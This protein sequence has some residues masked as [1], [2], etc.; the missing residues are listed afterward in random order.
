MSTLAI[1]LAATRR[2]A[3][4]SVKVEKSKHR[5]LSYRG[6]TADRD[7]LHTDCVRH[8]GKLVSI[9]RFMDMVD[10][11]Y[12][13]LEKA[14]VGQ[15][16]F[17]CINDVMKNGGRIR[18]FSIVQF[19]CHHPSAKHLFRTHEEPHYERWEKYTAVLP[20]TSRNRDLLRKL[21]I[22]HMATKDAVGEYRVVADE[23]K[24]LTLHKSPRKPS[25]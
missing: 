10:G 7:T 5:E 3:M 22:T 25:W 1:R 16:A 14:P 18:E 23:I 13:K 19:D 20:D 17:L 21:W 9:T 11:E 6:F 2:K 4:R 15:P 12:R 24:C 8:E